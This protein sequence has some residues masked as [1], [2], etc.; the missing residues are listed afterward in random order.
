MDDSLYWIWLSQVFS[1]G[2][3]KP[4]QILSACKS[5]RA[6]YEMDDSQRKSLAFLSE[7]DVRNAG[8][9]SLRR[10][11]KILSDCERIHVSVIPFDDERY[12][13]RLRMIYGP[14]M[15]LYA[16]GDISDLDSEVAIAV[17]GTRNATDYSLS[18]TEYLSS[19]MAA[20]GA[21]I[22]SGC[23]LGIDSCAHEGA[24]RAKGRTI[25]VLGCGLDV[26]YPQPN[27]DL[28]RRILES[29]GA[30]LSELPPGTQPLP[31]IFPVR[32]RLIAGISLGVLVTQAPERSGSLITAEHAVEQGKEV[33]CVPPYSIF[34]ARF[35]GVERYL[36]DGAIAVFSPS[37]ILDVYTY[38]YANKLD[39]SRLGRGYIEQKRKDGRQETVRRPE[40]P[41]IKKSL[42]PSVSEEYRE[43]LRQKQSETVSLL[44]EKQLLVYNNLDLTPRFIDELA[45]NTELPASE[46]TSVLTELE[47][48]GLAV[49]VGGRRYALA[50]K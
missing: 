22:V 1:C 6:F 50:E 40:E 46:L 9:V 5:P 28:K 4:M 24:L 27:H 2:S 29:G 32:N 37:D 49:N 26:D 19:E 16:L 45:D 38:A 3:D 44:H 47:L 10:A 43:Q 15:V 42:E 12:P 30:L 8:L 39:I 48:L 31:Q 20:A 41:K 35:F 7:K 17:V 36:R 13:D 21:I 25:A 18:V 33:F 23:A 11:E 34:D 14:P